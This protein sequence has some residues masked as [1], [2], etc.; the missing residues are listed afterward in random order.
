MILE[1]TTGRQKL[2]FAHPLSIHNYSAVQYDY[3]LILPTTN[4]SVLD[5]E[6]GGGG[7]GVEKSFLKN[8]GNQT[9]LA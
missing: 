6:G 1:G 7:V 3:R 4:I 5:D 2:L 9:F 8:K